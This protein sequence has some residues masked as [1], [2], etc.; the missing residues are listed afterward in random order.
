[1][2]SSSTAWTPEEGEEW[3]LRHDEDG[4]T[5][6]ILKRQRLDFSL[7]DPPA[8]AD[9]EAEEKRRRV[10]NRNVLLKVKA[11]YQMEI[12]QWELLSNTL[13]AMEARV[14]QQQLQVRERHQST[15]QTAAEETGSRGVEEEEEEEDPYGSLVDELLCKA[16]VQEGIIRNISNLCDVAEAVCDAHQDRLVQSFMDLRVWSSPQELMA[17]LCDE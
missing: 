5:Y 2:D 9:P 1:M 14:N 15:D 6:N 13:R 12:Q 11:R 16:E 17:S 4:F 10:R 7:S 8:P 3:E